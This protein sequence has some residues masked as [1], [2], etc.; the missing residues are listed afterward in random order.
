MALDELGDEA[1]I[2]LARK[3]WI[4]GAY[5]RGLGFL[6]W[7]RFGLLG[8]RRL[9]LLGRR[10]LGLL[11]RRG[12]GLL[13]WRSLRL[14]GTGLFYRRR[15]GLVLRRSLGLLDLA[16]PRLHTVNQFVARLPAVTAIVASWAILLLMPLPVA[17]VASPCRWACGC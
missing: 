17:D 5:G 13:F 4:K 2:K 3:G 6:G 1:S 15:L 16:G 12:L 10:G 9:G 14:A 8:R 7:R 11:G